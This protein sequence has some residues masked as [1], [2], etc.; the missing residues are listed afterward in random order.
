MTLFWF[1]PKNYLKY[2][3][4]KEIEAQRLDSIC[5]KIKDNLIFNNLVWDKLRDCLVST[6]L[7]RSRLDS[8]IGKREPRVMNWGWAAGCSWWKYPY[9]H[10]Y[11]IQFFE[12]CKINRTSASQLIFEPTQGILCINIY[13]VWYLMS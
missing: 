13:E 9:L 4:K 11:P 8:S 3:N 2:S 5:P 12:F 1:L 7:R 6:H 10:K